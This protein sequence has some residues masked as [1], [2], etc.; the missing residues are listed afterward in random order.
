MSKQII[1]LIDDDFR[2]LFT[3]LIYPFGVVHLKPDAAMGEVVSESAVLDIGLAI[4]LIEDRVE[5]VFVLDPCRI[6]DG[7][8]L[9]LS[10][11][12]HFAADLE[13]SLYRWCGLLASGALP[14]VLKIPFVL[15]AL[16]NTDSVLSAVN[17]NQVLC[18]A[19]CLFDL[20]PHD[21]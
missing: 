11:M 10:K 20:V 4:W 15:L 5:I 16:V 6:P 13:A 9:L 14:V 3:I 8:S 19:L 21:L 17:R 7:V 1:S 2:S 18:V 12:G